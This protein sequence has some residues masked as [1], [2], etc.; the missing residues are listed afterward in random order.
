VRVSTRVI[1]GLR[2]M[3]VLALQHGRGPISVARIAA[4]EQISFPYLEQLL[5]RLRKEGLVK[6]LRGA[7]GGYVLSAAPRE[8][9][10]G[11]IVQSLEGRNGAQFFPWNGKEQVATS[12]AAA[13]VAG[14]W[15]RL[16]ETAWEFLERMTLHDL[17]E[18]TKEA[19][20]APM[21]HR[22]TFHI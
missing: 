5:N 12:P 6:S 15:E 21:D 19:T 9:T 22:F 13:V 11:R 20:V 3:C 16:Q 2:A 14:V 17:L 8:I 18:E 1:Y 7:K 10:V 4:S